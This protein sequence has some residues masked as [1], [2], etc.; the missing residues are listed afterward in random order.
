MAVHNVWFASALGRIIEGKK[1]DYKSVASKI[2]YQ[3]GAAFVRSWVNGTGTPP[4]YRIA[5]IADA[6]SVPFEDLLLCWLIDHDL[7]HLER[8]EFIAALLMG[9]ATAANLFAEEDDDWEAPWWEMPRDPMP[10]ADA[11]RLIGVAPP[12]SYPKS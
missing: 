3:D 7:D 9:P 11:L 1:L 2:G 6:V 12:G 5:D 4:I 8:Y 10:L